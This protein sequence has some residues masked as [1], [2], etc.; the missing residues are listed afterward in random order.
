MFLEYV[1]PLLSVVVNFG[2]YLSVAIALKGEHLFLIC[3]GTILNRGPFLPGGRLAY[4]FHHLNDKNT[5]HAQAVAKQVMMSVQNLLEPLRCQQNLQISCII[6]YYS[7]TYRLLTLV[8]L[9][10]KLNFILFNN[11]SKCALLSLRIL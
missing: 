10:R 4:R 9:C 1:Y 2:C 3:T 8:C 6:F 5:A 11:R 7:V